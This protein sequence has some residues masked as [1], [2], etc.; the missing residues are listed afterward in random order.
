MFNVLS[1]A[2]VLVGAS[3]VSSQS[4]SQQ[5]QQ[6]L[7]QVAASPESSCLN[8]SGLTPLVVGGS[9]QSIVAPLNTW[10]QGFC[11]KPPCSNQDLS[12]IVTNITNGCSGDLSSLGFTSSQTSTIIAD[13]Q[14]YFPTAKQVACLKDDSTNQLCITETLTNIQNTVGSLTLSSIV[15]E[16]NS[17]VSASNG[18]PSSIVCT[19]CVKS[20]YNILNGVGGAPQG[21]SSALSNECGS[22][23]VDGQ[24][25]SGISNTASNLSSS[26]GAASGGPFIGM[27]MSAL[28]VV[29]SG[30]AI[31]A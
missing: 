13:V 7:V 24:N 6:T 27:A 28:T 16:M 15:S 31:L 30:F 17:I 12:D 21:A 19:N 2:A 10:L 26:S 3:L 20:A 9:N 11:S 8:P 1:I 4:I 14:K 23:F 25:P 22:S 5:C 29:L 18:V